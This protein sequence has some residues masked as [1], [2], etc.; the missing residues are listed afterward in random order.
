MSVKLSSAHS[1]FDTNPRLS[2]SSLHRSSISAYKY[3]KGYASETIGNVS[4]AS[5]WSQSGQKD[6]A[7]GAAEYKAAEK[8]G[9]VQG[10][11]DKASQGDVKGTTEGAGEAVKGAKDDVVGSVSG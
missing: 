9:Q 10:M 4:G 5:S 3:A 6:Q 2:C 11:T 8:S 7:E 1:S